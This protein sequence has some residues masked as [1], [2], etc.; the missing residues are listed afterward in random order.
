FIMFIE[1]TETGNL[2]DI[3]ITESLEIIFVTIMQH[4]VQTKMKHRRSLIP[5][6]RGTTS[7]KKHLPEARY[8]KVK[9]ILSEAYGGRSFFKA[10][11]CSGA[12]ILCIAKTQNGSTRREHEDILQLLFTNIMGAQCL[13][14]IFLIDEKLFQNIA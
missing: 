2:G 13:F 3:E 12:T 9:Q 6:K 10:G 1:I 5:S 8:E 4:I 11:L 7:S 14:S